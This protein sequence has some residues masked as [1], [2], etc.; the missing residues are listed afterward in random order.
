MMVRLTGDDSDEDDEDDAR[1]VVPPAPVARP[2]DPDALQAN[3][4]NNRPQQPQSQQQ[5]QQQRQR[6]PQQQQRQQ[7][8]APVNRIP[9]PERRKGIQL[10]LGDFV[11]YSVLVGRAALFDMSTVFTCTVAV[12]T[13]LFLTLLLLGIWRKALP[14]LPIS[15]FLGMVF[16]FLTR[17]FVLPFIEELALAGV[18]V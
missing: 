4:H 5:Q 10:G 16:Y 17:I 3:T 2:R 6:Q 1:R 12:I 7:Q 11:F 14:A 13:G 8:Q 18:F 15:I 9:A